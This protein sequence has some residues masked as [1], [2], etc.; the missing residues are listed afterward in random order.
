MPR[1]KGPSVDETIKNKNYMYHIRD[2]LLGYNEN[3]IW[4]YLCNFNNLQSFFDLFLFSKKNLDEFI[5]KDST[6]D[7]QTKNVIDLS[8]DKKY[9]KQILTL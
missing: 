4:Q 9:I 7:N 6:N 2:E 1:K 5:Y 3:N 8:H